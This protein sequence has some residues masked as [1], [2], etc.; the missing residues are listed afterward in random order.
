MI[1]TPKEV[2]FIDR[3]IWEIA[4]VVHDDIHSAQFEAHGER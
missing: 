4:C 2:D 1:A 3:A